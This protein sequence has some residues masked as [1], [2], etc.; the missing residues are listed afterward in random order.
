M[1]L[2]LLFLLE[3]FHPL[4]G[5]L[6]GR[7]SFWFSN[8]GLLVQHSYYLSFLPWNYY[9]LIIP[10]WIREVPHPWELEVRLA[11]SPGSQGE[12]FEVLK[13]R[14]FGINKYT[15]APPAL[16]D[17]FTPYPGEFFEKV[18]TAASWE[19]MFIFFIGFLNCL[20][21]LKSLGDMYRKINRILSQH[22]QRTSA[23]Y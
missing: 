6:K 5:H 4:V 10:L 21:A 13:T 19:S 20:E 7:Q 16:S 3:Q 17:F 18:N 22:S 15:E 14:V 12:K 9:H 23:R 1:V 8:S 2:S 11:I